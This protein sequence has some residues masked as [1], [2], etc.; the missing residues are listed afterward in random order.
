LNWMVGS[1]P[2]EQKWRTIVGGISGLNHKAIKFYGSGT[3]KYSQ[4]S[5]GGLR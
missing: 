1:M 5:K 4:M 2:F 3:M